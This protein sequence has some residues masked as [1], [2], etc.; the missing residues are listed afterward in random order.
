MERFNETRTTSE[1]QA[2]CAQIARLVAL[3]QRGEISVA[4]KRASIALENA[5]YYGT[6]GTALTS[7][8]QVI[9]E[10][11]YVLKVAS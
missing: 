9:D 1:Y 7:E 5:Q 3:W 8:P 11:A 6:T 10:V 4:V 2:H